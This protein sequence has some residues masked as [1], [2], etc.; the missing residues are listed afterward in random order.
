[1]YAWKQNSTADKMSAVPNLNLNLV[2]R[3]LTEFR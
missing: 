1:M 2:A 3:A